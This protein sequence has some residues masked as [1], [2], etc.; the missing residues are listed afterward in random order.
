VV[1]AI[2]TH[3]RYEDFL[4]ARAL[5]AIQ[6]SNTPNAEAYQTT[7]M[8][9]RYLDRYLRAQASAELRCF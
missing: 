6:L 3:L 2:A 7:V 1:D 8:T 9:K 4:R 5:S